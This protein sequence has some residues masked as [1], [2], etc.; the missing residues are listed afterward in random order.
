VPPR[1]SKSRAAAAETTADRPSARG[2]WTGSISFGL[3]TIPVE[4][5]AATR[6]VDLKTRMLS[7]DGEPLSR[8][9]VCPSDGRVLKDEEI[10]RGFEIEEG[11]FVPVSDAELE[12]LA[13]RRSRD[14]ELRSFVDR[15]AIDPAYFLRPFFVLPAGEQ[16]RAYRLLA[17]TME[18][19]RRSA[20]AD[21]VMRG[22]AYAIA[23]FADRGVLRAETLRFAD[24]LRPAAD[25][26]IP[27]VRKPDAALVGKMSKAIA[28][29]E[30]SELDERE[31]RDA[32]DAALLELARAK[33]KRGRDV[34]KIAESAEAHEPKADDDD[35]PAHGNVIDLFAVIQKRLRAAGKTSIRKAVK[36]TATPRKKAVGRRKPR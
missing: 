18:A 1:R 5:F 10:E 22:K 25:L 11:K 9:Y 3:V 8:Q 34:V 24:E 36:K 26:G 12:K 29:L 17:E 15:D 35:E 7:P 19:T 23:I 21:F 4:L 30:E 13:P 32:S 31:L 14:I 28:K 33:L 6:R 2:V 27:V 20:L 16:T